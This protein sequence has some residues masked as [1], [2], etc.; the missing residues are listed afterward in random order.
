MHLAIAEVVTILQYINTSN[1]HIIQLKL[2]QFYVSVISKFS[3]V[4]ES[5]CLTLCDPVDCSTPGLPVQNKQTKNY[6]KASNILLRIKRISL[7]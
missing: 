7:G 4:T 2:T 6:L 3:S 1:Q 5:S